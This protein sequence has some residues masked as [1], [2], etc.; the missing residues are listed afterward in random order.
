MSRAVV[1]LTI[2]LERHDHSRKLTDEDALALA[3]G[4]LDGADWW[5]DD[6]QYTVTVE[7]ATVLVNDSRKGA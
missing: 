3:E 2:S 1:K 6:Y 5:D 4:E 7:A